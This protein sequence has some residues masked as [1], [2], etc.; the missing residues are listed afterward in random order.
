MGGKKG[1]LSRL[2]VALDLQDEPFPGLPLI[3]IVGTDRLLL[4][5]HMGV[6]K[7]DDNEICVRVKYGV[8]YVMGFH[9]V[10]S[11]MSRDQLI[12]SGVIAGIKLERIDRQ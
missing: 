3:E 7:Y 4:E 12:I 9:L 5:H 10:I 2:A 1:I 6:I 8:V 11:K